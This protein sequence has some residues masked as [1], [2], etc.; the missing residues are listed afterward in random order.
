MITLPLQIRY[1]E[2]VL[3]QPAAWL[4]PGSEPQIWL[5]EIVAWGVPLEAAALH[6]IPRSAADLTPQGVL[7]VL[8][9]GL[10]PRTTHRSQAYAVFVVPPSGGNGPTRPPKGE[11]RAYTCL[12]KPAL[13]LRRPTLKWPHW[14]PPRSTVFSTQP[15][16]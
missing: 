10:K 15:W 1:D 16:A 12:W 8:P 3:R 2:K 14:P 9:E 6:P 4:I 5:D 11:V 13:T 7:V